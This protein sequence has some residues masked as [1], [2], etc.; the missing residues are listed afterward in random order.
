MDEIKMKIKV[1]S[2]RE[3][4]TTNE[5]SH[6]PRESWWGFFL[7]WSLSFLPKVGDFMQLGLRSAFSPLEIKLSSF[8]DTEPMVRSDLVSLRSCNCTCTNLVALLMGFYEG[9]HTLIYVKLWSACSLDRALL[10]RSLSLEQC[11]C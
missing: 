6:E 9:F 7:F 11:F 5:R 10:L 2:N 8:G 3:D 4:N 1:R